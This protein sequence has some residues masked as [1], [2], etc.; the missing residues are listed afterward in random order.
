MRN[1][2]IAL[3]VLISQFLIAQNTGSV[4]IGTLNPD[5]SAVLHLESSNQ[6]FLMVRTNTAGLGNINITQ[7]GNL[8]V[9]H[10]P[11]L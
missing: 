4:G 7:H 10:A 3:F 5:T 9:K 6:G 1:L 2:F 8:F 11:I